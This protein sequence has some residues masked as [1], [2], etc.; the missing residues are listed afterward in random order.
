[1]RQI[2]FA[3]M[4]Q[5]TGQ[6]PRLEAGITRVKAGNLIAMI[7]ANNG[8]ARADGAVRGDRHVI[9]VHAGLKKVPAVAVF[10]VITRMGQQGG[11]NAQ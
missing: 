5:L 9:T 10:K 11:C 3:N 6:T 8:A 1:M 4:R 7:V 2:N